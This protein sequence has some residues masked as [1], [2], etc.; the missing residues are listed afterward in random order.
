MVDA[1][2]HRQVGNGIVDV[3]DASDL[4]VD[5]GELLAVGDLRQALAQTEGV[6]LVR[7]CLGLHMLDERQPVH[8]VARLDR[9]D[10]DV[11]PLLPGRAQAIARQRKLP[12][13]LEDQRIEKQARLI[14]QA[15]LEL[16]AQ[17]RRQ[18]LA[19]ADALDHTHRQAHARGGEIDGQ[20]LRI[21]R[22][23][24][25]EVTVSEHRRRDRVVE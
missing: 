12:A 7:G 20:A 18:A 25:G 3:H 21:L 11:L 16:I 13:Q 24:V 15:P 1:L 14:V 10:G 4:R 22:S 19:V 9:V 5:R 23:G 6:A 2:C 8:H 17:Q